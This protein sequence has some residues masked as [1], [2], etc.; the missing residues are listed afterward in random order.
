[1][2]LDFSLTREQEEIRDLAHEFA[3]KEMRPVADHY[4]EKEETPWDVMRKAHEVGLSPASGFPEEYGGA[5]LDLLTTLIVQEELA[6]ATP[7]LP[8]PSAPA[9]WRA[10]GSSPWA[11]R[12]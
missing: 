9:G 4:D 8:Y 10:R 2:G 12:S 7:G 5:G 6:G 1:M 11:P 3:E